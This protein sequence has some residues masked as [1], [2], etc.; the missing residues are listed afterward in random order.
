MNI[1]LYSTGCPK[2]NVLKKKL[3]MA[4][5]E[6]EICE[7]EDVMEQKGFMSAPMLEVDEVVMDFGLAV[8][9]IAER[10]NN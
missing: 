2:C 4:K 10:I 3:D 1:I 9:W 7:D 6:Y 5:I 8:K